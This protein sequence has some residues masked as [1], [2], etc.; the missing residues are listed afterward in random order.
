MGDEQHGPIET[1]QRLFQ[2]GNR[3]D[4]QMVGGLVEQQQIR[5][6]HQCLGQQHAA[7]PPTGEL[8]QGAVSRQL[9]ATQG[10]VDQL[11]QAP[12]IL[13]L[14]RLL[15]M[16]ELLEIGLV[17]DVLAQV[18]VFGE[19]LA[20]AGQAFGDHI[21][22][23]AVIRSRKLLRQFADLQPRGTPDFAVIGRPIAFDQAQHA[24]FSGAITTNDADPLASR[25]LPGHAVQ[26]RRGA[27]GERYI[28][29]LEQGHDYL[30]K[31]GRAV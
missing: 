30:R 27:V 2:P 13:R 6:G 1:G 14:E 21:E 31:T 12:A 15:Y 7:A 25:D 8:G 9:Q 28:G 29:E 22:Y 23:R 20:D 10:A 5:L 26:Q 24:G 19:Q 3:A 17:L 11:L 16:H 4:I 18:M